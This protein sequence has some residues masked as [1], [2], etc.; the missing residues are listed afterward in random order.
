M[1]YQP[2]LE[3]VLRAETHAFLDTIGIPICDS[4]KTQQKIRH[5]YEQHL[6]SIMTHKSTPNQYFSTH[7][8]FKKNV[9]NLQ[10][11]PDRAIYIARESIKLFESWQ[12]FL[13]YFEDAYTHRK[14]EHLNSIATI[15]AAAQFRRIIGLEELMCSQGYISLAGLRK[16]QHEYDKKN[17]IHFIF[18]KRDEYMQKY[19]FDAANFDTELLPEFPESR[20]A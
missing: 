16:V 2:W 14:N 8:F 19:L 18:I 9:F 1:S 6:Q 10:S 15:N 11:N 17:P 5:M 3:F 20:V 4:R 13:N 12:L 7:P